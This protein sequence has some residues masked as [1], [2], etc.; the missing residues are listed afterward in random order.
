MRIQKYLSQQGI[1]SRREAERYLLKGWI[2]V[3]GVCVKELGVRINPELDKVTL[4]EPQGFVKR[5]LVAFHKPPGV[6][7]H[8]AQKDEFE[9]KDI[10]PDEFKHLA[11]IGRLDKASEG[12][13]LLT[14][15]G[16]W[17]KEL[18]QVKP[19]H[20][21]VYEVDLNSVLT[22]KQIEKC[23]RGIMLFG[24]KT[25][26]LSCR[27]LKNLPMGGA[28]YDWRMF[29]GKNRQIRRM[30][31]KVGVRVLKLKRLSFGEFQLGAL[32]RGQCHILRS[33]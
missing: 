10:L 26:P 20:E 29:E 7:T 9:I 30:T 27:F 6:V 14:N 25:L 4:H 21:R 31:Q 18:L 8:S 24:Q 2:K 23:E 28:R 17:A 5:L 19:A 3:N 33:S 12:L 32:E 16:V 11:P 15:H 13:I 22:P 1:L